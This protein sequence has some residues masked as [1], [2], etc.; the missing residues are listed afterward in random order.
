M[1]MDDECQLVMD[2]PPGVTDE[3][4]EALR[5]VLRQYAEDTVAHMTCHRL[6]A[7]LAQWGLCILT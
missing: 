5:S 6:Q 2:R 1:S 3:Q 7:I 4:F